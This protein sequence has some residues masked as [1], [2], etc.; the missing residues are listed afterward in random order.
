MALGECGYKLMSL[1]S[2]DRE[3]KKRKIQPTKNILLQI[4]SNSLVLSMDKALSSMLSYM[5]VLFP[6]TFL[7]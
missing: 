5:L 7:I 3:H 2:L 6:R 1:S 4:H